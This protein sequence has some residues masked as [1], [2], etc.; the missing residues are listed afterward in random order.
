MPKEI[1][2]RVHNTSSTGVSFFSLT[3]YVTNWTKMES[4][5][6]PQAE[7][8][9]GDLE[10]NRVPIQIGGNENPLGNAVTKDLQLLNSR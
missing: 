4:C 8:S 10:S 2:E 3:M 1:K 7:P 6:L 9:S 5:C